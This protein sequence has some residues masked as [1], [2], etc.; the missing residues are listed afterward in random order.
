M[1]P[2]AARPQ[3]AQP[4]QDDRARVEAEARERAIAR[5]IAQ[6]SSQLTLFDRQGKVV[7]TVGPRDLYTQPVLSPD[8]ARVAVIVPDLHKQT[9]DLW[10]VDVASG[11]RTQV[12]ASQPREPVA[13]PA[14]S[15]DGKYV[16]YVGLRGSRY[17]LY[18]KPSDGSGTEEL[19]YEH[20][21]G[22]IVL[23]D[24]SLD[25][26]FLSYYASDLSGS[27]LFLLPLDGSR[28][29]VEVAHSDK[30]IVAAR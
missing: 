20:Q 21:G 25:G 9:N 19:V 13:A 16:G 28:Q 6:N 30:Q 14:W 26:R 27:S 22:P 11:Q 17:G 8:R 23:T 2:V 29:P 5:A 24:W 15:P 7:A 18:R 4:Q 3:G 12:T 1:I 10:V